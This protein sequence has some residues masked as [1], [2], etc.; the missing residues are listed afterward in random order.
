MSETYFVGN[1]TG[2]LISLN[3][4]LREA[5]YFYALRRTEEGDLYFT[6]TDTMLDT[7]TITINQLIYPT[8]QDFP[9]FE[10]GTDFFEGVGENHERTY[11][12][13][14]YDQYKWDSSNFFY[15]LNEN[16]EL[17]VRVNQGYTYTNPDV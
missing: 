1:G 6:K 15:Y 17:V 8:T 13:L 7:D 16:G 12:N 14:V 4:I 3:P 5:R 2:D 11:L 10:F 9:D